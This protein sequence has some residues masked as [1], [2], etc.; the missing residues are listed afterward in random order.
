M[1]AC[2]DNVRCSFTVNLGP[3]KEVEIIF[4]A[5][6]T[7][8]VGEERMD[9][10]LS[11]PEQ[12][13]TMTNFMDTVLAQRAPS[14]SFAADKQLT[15]TIAL[16]TIQTQTCQTPTTRPKRVQC[17]RCWAWL[18]RRDLLLRHKRVMHGGDERPKYPCPQCAKVFSRN[19]NLKRHFGLIHGTKTTL[20]AVADSRSLSLGP[21][22]PSQWAAPLPDAEP[23]TEFR[24]PTQWSDSG[25]EAWLDYE[26]MSQAQTILLAAPSYPPI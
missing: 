7:K 11:V 23:D 17:D 12:N 22:A 6:S 26:T 3:R 1:R 14:T 2:G 5:P 13:E 4:K 21:N 24:T 9:A 20:A 19:D 18:A 8:T 25:S 10:Y 16:N 15:Y